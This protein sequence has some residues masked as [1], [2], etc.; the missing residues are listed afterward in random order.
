MAE[1]GEVRSGAAAGQPAAWD[2]LSGLL[3]QVR[4]KLSES[5]EKLAGLAWPAP[6]RQARE[7]GATAGRHLVYVHGICKHDPGFSNPWWEAL[8]PFTI[9]FGAGDLGDTRQEVVWSDLVEGS[10]VA[11]RAAAAPADGRAEWAARVRGVLEERAATH[12]VE[13]GPVVTSPALARDLLSRELHGRDV[14]DRDFSLSANLT[15]P[16]IGCVDDFTVYMFN[17]SVRAQIIA[18]FTGVVRPLLEAGDELDIIAHSWGTVVAYEGLRQ[19]EDDG[20]TVPGV[21]NFFT[22]GAA[23]SIFL[24]K[25]RLRPANRDGHRPAAVRRWVNL[26]A[27]GDPVGG[28]LQGR[29]YQVDAE[30]L[31]LLN[32][33]CGRFDASCAHGSYFQPDNVEVNRDI[34]AAFIDR[35]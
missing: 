31:D 20:V 30:F 9:A 21:R 14:V 13:T 16:G 4:Q 22:A 33:G 1:Q 11:I 35:P 26:N 2:Q 25:L 3:E 5:Q 17:D 34:F 29:P 27:H 15:V 23:L 10:G 19:L 18:R 24:V 7:A 8:H 6:A 32:H 28:P 12:A